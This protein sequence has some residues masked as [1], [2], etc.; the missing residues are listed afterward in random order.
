MKSRSELQ[1][2]LVNYFENHQDNSQ[3]KMNNLLR[4]LQGN[5]DDTYNDDAFFDHNDYNIHSKNHFNQNSKGSLPFV[6]LK[7]TQSRNQNYDE[8][9]NKNLTVS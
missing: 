9:L 1:N 7:N 6:K 4:I 5:Q 2:T 8:R 3:N